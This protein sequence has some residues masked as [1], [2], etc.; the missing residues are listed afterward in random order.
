[1]INVITGTINR[2]DAQTITVLT[3]PIGFAVTVP[4]IHTYTIDQ[5][6]ELHAHMHWNQ[7]NGPTL[8]G[9]ATEL[10]KTI[11]LLVISCSGIGPKLGIA[12]LN[13]LGPDGFLSAVT[14]GSAKQLSTVSGI[15]L[16]KA[17]Q[18]IVQSKSKV[19]KLLESGI[20]VSSSATQLSEVRQTL[21]SLNYSNA[22]VQHALEYVKQ[23]D[24]YVGASFDQL[25]RTALL[26]LSKQ[27]S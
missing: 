22:E 7:E 15:G 6:V 20:Q 14:E 3:G 24:N 16:K 25:L 1:M 4:N 27:S 21:S 26:Y 17:E 18:I 13:D 11:F 5:K 9:F 23:K 8:F 2:K 19:A 12:V 10:E